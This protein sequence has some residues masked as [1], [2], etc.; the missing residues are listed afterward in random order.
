MVCSLASSFHQV[1]FHPSMAGPLDKR[2]PTHQKTQSSQTHICHFVVVLHLFER[3]S[4]SLFAPPPPFLHSS[5]AV[6]RHDFTEHVGAAHCALLPETRQQIQ[7]RRVNWE[8]LDPS[9]DRL[10][11]TCSVLRKLL[12]CSGYE[13]TS[14]GPLCWL[15][16]ILTHKAVDLTFLPQCQSSI[17]TFRWL[18]TLTIWSEQ[19]Y[20]T[21]FYIF[22]A[23][24]GHI[25]LFR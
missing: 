7:E 21:L 24:K 9:A 23:E 3:Y 22:Y 12:V 11:P 5:G 19:I 8:K 25:F 10:I 14:D 20:F 17:L 15:F 2:P 4:C 6:H 16:V 18:K 1:V 13:R